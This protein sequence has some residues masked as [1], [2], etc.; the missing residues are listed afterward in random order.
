M[1]QDIADRLEILEGQRA[2]AKQL[3]RQA[4]RAHMNSEEELLSV[5]I[6]F[7]NRCIWD[8]YMEDAEDWLASLPERN[9]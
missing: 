2:E 3:R 9:A 1:K 8:C 6:S 7:T 4:K 5:F